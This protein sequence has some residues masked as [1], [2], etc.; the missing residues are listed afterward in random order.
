[1][2]EISLQDIKIIEIP[3]RLASKL[4]AMW[5]SVLPRI[6]WSNIVRNKYY[7]CFGAYYDYFNWLAVG[8]WSSPVAGNRMKDSDKILEL[9]RLA[10]SSQASKNTATWFLAR[11]IKKIKVKFPEIKKL[12]SYQDKT[13]HQ[14]TIYKAGNWQIDSEVK[15][16]DWDKTRKRN[17]AQS[18]SDKIRWCYYL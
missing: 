14:G 12:I 3:P 2:A 9:R 18:K 4:N 13:K 11:M 7:I 15:Y 10:I 1:M 16:M 6:H 8:I 17:P 5:H